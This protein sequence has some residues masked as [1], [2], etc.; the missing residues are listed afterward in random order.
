M[1]LCKRIAVVLLLLSVFGIPGVDG[2]VLPIPKPV[3][4]PFPAE[5]SWLLVAA[6]AQ[7]LSG[8]E[9]AAS[10][11]AVRDSVENRRVLDYDRKNAGETWDDALSWAKGNSNGAPW[12]VYRNGSQASE[13]EL[14]GS[15]DEMKDTLTQAI[16]EGS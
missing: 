13:G 3:A 2:G 6:E 7:N 8:A 9:V 16:G 14:S 1:T 12:Y 15:V 11:K 10:A 5:G 4:S